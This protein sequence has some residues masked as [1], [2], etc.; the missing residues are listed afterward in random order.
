MDERHTAR[1]CHK[2]ILHHEA[3]DFVACMHA[4]A[5]ARHLH[6]GGRLDNGSS[7]VF[8]A[9]L[10]STVHEQHHFSAAL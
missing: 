3:E 7:M 4:E 9:H 8:R 6:V 2:E 5:C 1:C 10:C